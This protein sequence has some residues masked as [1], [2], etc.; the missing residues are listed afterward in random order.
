MPKRSSTVVLQIVFLVIL[1]VSIGQVTW[2][3]I[4]NLKYSA[5]VRDSVSA[6]YVREAEVA[7]EL[8]DAGISSAEL[9]DLFPHVV[10][11]GGRLVV[12]QAAIDSLVTARYHRVNRMG[13]EGTFFLVVLICAMGVIAKAIRQD[14]MFRSRQR[15]FIAAVTHELKSPLASLQLAAETLTLREPT[16]DDFKRLTGR[17]MSDIARLNGLVTNVLDASRLETESV[18]TTGSIVLAD[19]LTGAVAEIRDRARAAG[20]V[21]ELNNETRATIQ[22]DPLGVRTV[23]RNVLDNAIKATAA[24]DEGRIEIIARDLEGQ[25]Q[26]VVS[27]NGI[28]F[29]PEESKRLFERFFRPGNEL[30]RETQGTGLGLFIV[31]RLMELD[32]GTALAR[33]EGHGKG[34]AFVLSWPRVETAG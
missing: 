22:A 34:A 21:L 25:V 2:W 11:D 17:M 31:K 33:S 28:G 23:L 4:D 16:P 32:G 10:T 29:R 14:S 26:V 7:N 5:H 18:R 9:H 24:V 27:D 19:E 30:R 12:N 20:L 3:I 13:W 6:L 15:N 8:A 1:L